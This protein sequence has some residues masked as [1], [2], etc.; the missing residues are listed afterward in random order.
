MY[1]C[2]HKVWAYV[3][4]GAVP[5]GQR[6]FFA[7]MLAPLV[8]GG[9]ALPIWANQK[10]RDMKT[11]SEMGRFRRKYRVMQLAYDL[12]QFAVV[13][14]SSKG[15]NVGLD[16]PLCCRIPMWV[17]W[18]NGLTTIVDLLIFKGPDW[19]LDKFGLGGPE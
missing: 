14:G 8:G 4:L 16:L 15:S 12:L 18:A 19:F 5:P 6:M 7:A 3:T 10:W 17:L 9:V 11:N 1:T 2:I 13:I